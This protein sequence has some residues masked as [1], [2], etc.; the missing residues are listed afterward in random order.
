MQDNPTRWA[1]LFLFVSILFGATVRFAPTL[2]TGSPINDGGMFLVLIEN[3][4]SNHFL[5]PAFTSYNNLNLPFAYP[6]FSFYV[7]GLLSSL[8]IP[9]LDVIRWLPPLVST[10]SIPAFYWMASLMLDSRTRAALATLAYA[11]MPRSFSWYIM[12]GGLSRSFGV[13]FLL[14]SCASAWV[15]FN[16]RA[17]KYVFLT[18]LFGAGAILSHPETGLHAAA[19]CALIWL[20]KGRNAGG[21]RDA[22]LVSLGVFAL[23]SPWWGTVVIQHGLSPFQS[24]L[25]TGGHGALFWLP[26]I[27]FDFAEERFVTLF[28]VLG[29]IGFAVRAM[30]R[31]WFLPA[32]VFVPFLV[33]PRSA[34]A[35]AALPLA[36]LAGVGLSDFVIP[37][38]ASLV[39]KSGTETGDWTV[40]VSRSRL[41]RIVMGYVA[42]S[43]LVGA[44]FYDLSLANYVVPSDSRDAMAWVRGNTPSDSRFI[45][46]TG[47]A[48][49]FSDPVAEWFPAFA[50][51]TSQNTIQG[52]EW[53]LGGNFMPFLNG[54]QSLQ[55]CLNDSPYCAT[56][57]A[58]AN[59]VDFD[60]I[61]ILK[62]ENNPPQPS[63]LLLYLLRR[64][65]NYALVFENGGAVIFE[66][67]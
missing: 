42:F 51:R 48:D 22:F 9:T 38:L 66:R 67:K 24:A 64:D 17:P 37:G 53:L 1:G 57:W 30:R 21:L 46:L 29:L 8:G 65:P 36:I 19:A 28:T 4:K 14:L 59:E 44:F 20:F 26:W 7:G 34:V 3:L 27:T 23:T 43:G 25:N 32:W 40:F 18:A 11:L 5:I 63:G 45:V 47:S 62:H 10:L 31:D 13:L 49:P 58:A 33:E 6:P 54:L 41:P 52:R 61:Y 35:I 50:A 2:M 16:Q 56:H 60:Y 39:S 12:G 55:T 15:L